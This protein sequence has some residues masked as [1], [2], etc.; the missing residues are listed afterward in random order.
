[1]TTPQE[2]QQAFL[3]YRRDGFGGWPWKSD[4]PVHDAS[5]GRFARHADGRVEKLG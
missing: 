4:A 2:I 3:D 1:M 5:E